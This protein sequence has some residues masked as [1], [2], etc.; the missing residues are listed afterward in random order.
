MRKN[1]QFT[2]YEHKQILTIVL[3]GKLEK[4]NL[5]QIHKIIC[6]VMN[7]LVKAYQIAPHEQ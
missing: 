1:G 7:D 2:I 5:E 6:L 3:L 4:T